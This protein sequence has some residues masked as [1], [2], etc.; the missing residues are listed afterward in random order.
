MATEF[1]T[2]FPTAFIL[3]FRR[4]PARRNPRP[5]LPRSQIDHFD[6]VSEMIFTKSAIFN[7]VCSLTAYKL[8]DGIGLLHNW[9]LRRKT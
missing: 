5:D 8:L 2:A 3:S 1:Q 7:T 9:T 6:A 4:A